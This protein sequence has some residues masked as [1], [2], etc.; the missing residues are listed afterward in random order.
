MLL[1]LFDIFM[2]AVPKALLFVIKMNLKPV[3]T[4]LYFS[5]D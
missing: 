3:V 1:K 2:L 4:K 5:R